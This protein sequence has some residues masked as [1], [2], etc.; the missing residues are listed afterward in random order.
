VTTP[1]ADEFQILGPDLIVIGLL[2]YS[3]E[4]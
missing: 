3:P 4:F 2:Q 1:I